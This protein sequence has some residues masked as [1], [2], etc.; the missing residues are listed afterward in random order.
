MPSYLES[1]Y[2]SLSA[3]TTHCIR[4]QYKHLCLTMFWVAATVV[5][6]T[7]SLAQRIG[8]PKPAPSIPGSNYAKRCNP[9]GLRNSKGPL[10]Y[11][12][13]SKGIRAMDTLLAKYFRNERYNTI[14]KYV[15]RY[16]G[17]IGKHKI[18]EYKRNISSWSG[19]PRNK[20]IDLSN[21]KMRNAILAAALRQESGGDWRNYVN[22]LFFEEQLVAEED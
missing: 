22:A 21:R 4:I 7:T 18:E 11:A 1:S 12:S 19:I 8:M 20:V 5:F 9:G 17:N 3:A 10:R 14:E 16:A 13:V 2:V 15:P 6:A